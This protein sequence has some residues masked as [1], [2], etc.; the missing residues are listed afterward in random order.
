MPV[1]GAAIFT[2][3]LQIWHGQNGIDIWRVVGPW[4]NFRRDPTKYESL[5]ILLPMPYQFQKLSNRLQLF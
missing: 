5:D 3:N 4:V 2:T 1:L